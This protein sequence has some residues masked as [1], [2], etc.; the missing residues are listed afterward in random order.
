MI[1]SLHSKILYTTREYEGDGITVTV[2]PH[3]ITKKGGHYMQ[4]NL[5]K[6]KINGKLKGVKCADD[7]PKICYTP[8]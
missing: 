2:D 3:Q 4:K 1:N 5:I 7:R 8:K 6:E